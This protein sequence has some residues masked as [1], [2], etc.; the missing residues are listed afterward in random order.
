ML[1]VT[2]YH[3]FFAQWCP[4]SRLHARNGGIN[5]SKFLYVRDFPEYTCNIAQIQANIVW[6]LKS[7]KTYSRYLKKIPPSENLSLFGATQY[8]VLDLC[9]RVEPTEGAVTQIVE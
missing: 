7:R 6:V 1:G 2:F 4:P 8:I 3:R 5:F 9:L